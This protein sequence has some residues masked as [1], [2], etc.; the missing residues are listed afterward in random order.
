M[1]KQAHQ[2]AKTLLLTPQ[3]QREVH[4]LIQDHLEEGGLILAQVFGDGLHIRVLTPQQARDSKPIMGAGIGQAHWLRSL[5]RRLNRTAVRPVRL[6]AQLY[7]WIDMTAT[8]KMRP[9][10]KRHPHGYGWVCHCG[11]HGKTHAG[12]EVH[13]RRAARGL[14][15]KPYNSAFGRQP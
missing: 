14:G 2:H 13:N 10:W 9:K 3:Q 8:N 4:Q 1:A 12:Q 7:V 6:K 11:Y 15:C 5:Q